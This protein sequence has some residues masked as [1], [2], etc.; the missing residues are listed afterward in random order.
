VVELAAAPLL[1]VTETLLL[2][3]A[4]VAIGLTLAHRKSARKRQRQVVLFL[5][6]MLAMLFGS[7]AVPGSSVAHLLLLAVPLTLYVPY[8]F[9]DKN[10]AV[11]SSVLYCV[12]LAAALTMVF[13][14]ISGFAIP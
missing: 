5:A 9:P 7:L 3:L 1:L 2:T 8:A 6:V 14:R 13:L 11:V 12:V 10:T 4:C